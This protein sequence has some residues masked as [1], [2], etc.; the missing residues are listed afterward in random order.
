MLSGWTMLSSVY[1][2][3]V[4]IGVCKALFCTTQRWLRH[5]LSLHIAFHLVGIGTGGY[6]DTNPI[7]RQH[8]RGQKESSWR[9]GYGDAVSDIRDWNSLWNIWISVLKGRPLLIARF[10]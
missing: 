4:S 3:R 1:I 7:I 9:N 5:I 10:N 6:H 8:Y 2:S